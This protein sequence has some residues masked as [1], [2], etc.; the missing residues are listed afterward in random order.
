MLPSRAQSE[1]G[2]GGGHGVN[3]PFL[4]FVFTLSPLQV[5]PPPP[6]L[7]LMEG[8]AAEDKEEEEEVGRKTAGWISSL[9][10]DVCCDLMTTSLTD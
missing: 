1:R 8:S 7:K 3:R 5:L 2:G 9:C 4:R 10:S 6:S